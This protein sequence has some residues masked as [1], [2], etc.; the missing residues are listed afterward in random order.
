MD[1]RTLIK[2][3]LN[4]GLT[5][6]DLATR[7]RISHGTI[8]KILFTET[9]QKVATL[10]KI[11]DY[12]KIPIHEIM[13]GG[14]DPAGSRGKPSPSLQERYIARLEKEIDIASDR[15]KEQGKRLDK[16]AEHLLL[17][18]ARISEIEKRL[19]EFADTGD[20][21]PLKNLGNSG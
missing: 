3:E 5:Q 17:L 18:H 9:E 7:I 8:Q 19:R 14:S 15:I 20:P 10:Q 13:G 12:F 21:Q 6:R 1:V 2:D 11:A 4:K 16:Q